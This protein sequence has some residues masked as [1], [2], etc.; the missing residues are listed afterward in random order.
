MNKK[1][2]WLI[3]RSADPVIG[4]VTLTVQNIKRMLAFYIDV[5]GFRVYEQGQKKVSLTADGKTVLLKLE[6]DK[7]AKLRPPHTT[8]LYHIAFLLPERADLADVIKHLAE[9]RYPLQ[10][11]SDHDV[12]EALYLADPEGNGLEIYAD[13]DAASWEWKKDQV[14]MTTKPL[15]IDDL[16]MDASGTGWNGMPS[17][18]LIGHIHLQVSDLE[19][20]KR[21]YC[22]GISF[23]PVL[24]YGSQALFISWHKYHHHIGLNTWNSAGAGP[25]EEKSTGLK[26]F[27]I[28]FSDEAK[29]RK[30]VARLEKLN[31]WII[32]ENGAIITKDPS[33]IYLI[34]EV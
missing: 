16:L 10:G 18:T 25:P 14:F 5:L 3:V 32:E 13:R 26:H 8:G 11:A 6:E 15:D 34:L 33:G 1:E 30:A 28:F 17:G 2:E 12:S 7:G 9:I 31:A 21:F 20:A 29:R 24:Q 4:T 23:D 27:T 19:D 22:D